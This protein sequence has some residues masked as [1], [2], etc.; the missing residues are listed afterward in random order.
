M[1]GAL[2]AILV[3]VMGANGAVKNWLKISG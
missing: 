1:Q 2:V 3:E